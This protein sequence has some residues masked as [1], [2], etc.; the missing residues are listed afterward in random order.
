MNDIGD[1]SGA[2]PMA[3][4][5]DQA[6]VRSLPPPPVPPHFRARL[7]A[8]IARAP[9]VDAQFSRA[10]LEAEHDQQLRALKSGYIR[11]QRRTLGMLVGAAF[12]TGVIVTLAMPWIRANYGEN[13]VFAVPLVGALVGVGIG[14]FSWLQRTVAARLLR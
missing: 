8:A 2:T 6:L 4:A 14:A 5:L 13:A 11:V 1:T 3:Q 9:R 12:A 10:A 7:L